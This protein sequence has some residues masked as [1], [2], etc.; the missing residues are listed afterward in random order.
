MTPLNEA[1]RSAPPSEAPDG[2]QECTGKGA[3]QK[4]QAECRRNEL[5]ERLSLGMRDFASLL[6]GVSLVRRPARVLP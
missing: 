6:L 4:L 3:R 5:C 1:T 2:E